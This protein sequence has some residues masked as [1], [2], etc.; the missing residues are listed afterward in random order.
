MNFL[1]KKEKRIPNPWKEGMMSDGVVEPFEGSYDV[2]V[3][4]KPLGRWKSITPRETL[5]KNDFT[6]GCETLGKM[7]DAVRSFSQSLR[8]L[9]HKVVLGTWRW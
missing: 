4:F 7:D 5:G 2:R 6:G 3:N 8:V 1:E 9:C